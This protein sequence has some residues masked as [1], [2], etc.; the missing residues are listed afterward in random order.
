MAI[1]E[2]CCGD[3]LSVYEA[4]A[5]GA[6]R[7]EL[8][9]GLGDGG[10]T[11]SAGLIRRAVASGLPV[12]V[13][14][15]PRPG[16]FL[17]SD[18]EMDVMVADIEMALGLGANGVV[19]GVL[20]PEGN[21][22]MEKCGRL[23]DAAREV[24]SRKVEVTF[25]RAFDLCRDPFKSLEDII[26]LGCGTI[27]TSGLASSA[28]AGM[29][30][31]GKLVEAAVGRIAIMAGA[32]INPGSAGAILLNARVDAIHA[33]ARS[34]RPSGM[35]FRRESVPMGVPGADEYSLSFTDR[36]IVSQLRFLLNL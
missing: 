4:K 15:R 25:H 9:S 29:N 33:T 20:T 1:L 10:L 30:M 6:D 19:V 35:R 11:P 28:Y 13:L 22:D 8:C 3:I 21:V 23:V 7:I 32:G 34:L 17:Y 12:N 31:L 16:D 5:G 18:E 24:G 26:E 14:I 36:G 2:I 27:L